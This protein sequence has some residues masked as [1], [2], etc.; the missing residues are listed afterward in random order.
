MLF[1][2]L[3]FVEPPLLRARYSRLCYSQTITPGHVFDKQNLTYLPSCIMVTLQFFCSNNVFRN[4][5]PTR[6]SQNK[7]WFII[8]AW[9]FFLLCR[10]NCRPKLRRHNDNQHREKWLFKLGVPCFRLPQCHLF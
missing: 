10:C 9:K 6:I 3:V 2:N 4:Y 7:I 1:S 8:N 5:I